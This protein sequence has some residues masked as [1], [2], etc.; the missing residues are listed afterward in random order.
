MEFDLKQATEILERTPAALTSMVSGLS[1]G[2]TDSVR[3]RDNWQPYDVIGHLIHGEKTDWIPRARII[4]AQEGDVR[5][6]PYDRWAQFKDS[7]GKSLAE[8]LEEFAARRADNLEI[9]RTWNLTDEQLDLQGT[10]PELGR[11]KLRQLLATWVVHDL[12]H[13]RQIAASMAGRYSDQVGVWK[14]YLSILN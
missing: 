7:E 14:E 13:V 1:S 5:F 10:H 3:D 2:W 9:L 6:E 12:T 4:L 8:L 11:V